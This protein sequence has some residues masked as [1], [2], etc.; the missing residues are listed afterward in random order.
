MTRFGLWICMSKSTHDFWLWF[1]TPSR[2]RSHGVISILETTDLYRLQSCKNKW[3]L[4][5]KSG[6][7]TMREKFPRKKELASLS[8]DGRCWSTVSSF[9]TRPLTK[10]R[11]RKVTLGETYAHQFKPIGQF[12]LPKNQTEVAPTKTGICLTPTEYSKLKA[13]GVFNHRTQ[14]FIYWIS[15][16]TWEKKKETSPWWSEILFRNW[17]LLF[18]VPT[19]RFT[20]I[21]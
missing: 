11:I 10:K 5:F 6:T 14:T 8:T 3:E 4:T 9:W 1:T 17:T 13:C 20:W 19:D 18:L 7:P 16:F 21:S 12:W 2:W 15:S